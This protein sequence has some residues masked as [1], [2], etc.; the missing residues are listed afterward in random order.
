LRWL[1]AQYQRASQT[2]LGGCGGRLAAMIAVTSAGG[3]QVVSTLRQGI[4]HQKL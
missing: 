4:S 2:L 3:D 1:A